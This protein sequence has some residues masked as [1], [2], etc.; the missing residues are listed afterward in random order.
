MC[1]WTIWNVT[2]PNCYTVNVKYIPDPE[3]LTHPP[4]KKKPHNPNASINILTLVLY[5]RYLFLKYIKI[6]HL[7]LLTFKNVATIKF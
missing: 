3:S 5:Y 1:Y 7:F 4:K 6:N 2:N